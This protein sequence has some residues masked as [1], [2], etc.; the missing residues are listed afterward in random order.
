MRENGYYY[1]IKKDKTTRLGKLTHNSTGYD[2][3]MSLLELKKYPKSEWRQRIKELQYVISLFVS[4]FEDL[5]EVVI[6]QDW[7]DDVKAKKIAKSAK[8]VQTIPGTT[9]VKRVKLEGEVTGKVALELQ[10]YVDGK[11]C[12]FEPL[13][14]QMNSAHRNPYTVIYGNREDE[15]IFQKWYE[16]VNSN[17]IKLI[18]YSER[19]LNRLKDIK[20]HNF[21]KLE[22]FEKGKNKLFKRIVTA[23]RIDQLINDYSSIFSRNDIIISRISTPLSEKLD[24]LKKYRDE[25]YKSGHGELINSILELADSQGLYDSSIYDVYKEIKYVF[26]RLPF[27]KEICNLTSYYHVSDEVIRLITDLFKYHKYRVNW[28]LYKLPTIDEEEV[29]IREGEEIND[30]TI[31]Q[32]I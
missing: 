5:G 18:I 19:E 27:L 21:M 14:I 11:N 6:P 8:L 13:V 9:K 15:G 4:K 25:Y 32:L 3:Y 7:L 28:Q 1:F 30:E 12:K 17:K 16:L 10:R 2:N 23:H 24:R 22:E 26:D 20:L 29:E 31:K